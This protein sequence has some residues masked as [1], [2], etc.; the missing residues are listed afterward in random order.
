MQNTKINKNNKITMMITRCG[1]MVN[2]NRPPIATTPIEMI[3]LIVYER[4]L[5]RRSSANDHFLLLICSFSALAAAIFECLQ[6]CQ[7]LIS[8]YMTK[9]GTRGI[10]PHSTLVL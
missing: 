3:C 6:L 9:R 4:G 8:M 2:D 10:A 1:Q 7:F 5:V